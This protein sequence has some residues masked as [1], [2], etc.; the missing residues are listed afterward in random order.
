MTP[1]PTAVRSR[2]TTSTRS[3]IRLSEITAV[4]AGGIEPPWPKRLIYSQVS[5]P[6]CSTHPRL[7]A[8]DGNRTRSSDMASRHA[9]RTPHPHSL[10]L[11]SGAPLLFF[12]MTSWSLRTHVP[13]CSTRRFSDERTQLSRCVAPRVAS[14]H[15][16]QGGSRTLTPGIR[17]P[18]STVDLHGHCKPAGCRS[19][20]ARFW[21]P[22]WSPDPGLCPSCFSDL[23]NEE[24]RVSFEPGLREVPCGVFF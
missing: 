16:A 13:Y 12:E 23:Q 11:T 20:V 22:R 14:G 9:A 5:P 4:D 24:G 7:R 8:S 19:P 2:R 3:T 10:Q 18:S 15:G 1:A 21:R 6:R 17:D